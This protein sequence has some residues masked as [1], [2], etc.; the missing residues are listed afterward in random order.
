MSLDLTG[1]SD[2]S[3][4]RASLPSELADALIANIRSGELAIGSKLASEPKLAKAFNVSRNTVREAIGILREQRFVVTRHGI[5]TFVLGEGQVSVLPVEVGIEQL[6]STTELIS[7]AGRVPGS[8]DYTLSV[9]RAAGL[10]ED[11]Q[12]G[13]DEE[14][15]AIERVRTADG[16]PV[17]LCRDYIR[18][19]AIQSEV[20]EKY[21]GDESLFEFLERERGFAIQAARA[22]IVPIM[23]TRRIAELLQVPR[24]KPLLA[25]YQVH[26]AEGA[27]S[28]L[29][30]E[31]YFNLDYIDVHVR[32]TPVS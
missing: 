21:H 24:S 23:P 4:R 2:W 18:T 17:I 1:L 31:N 20:I 25:L 32:R 26:Y 7:R 8:R 5:G 10:S 28:F 11:F 27:N 6:T 12:L 16:L 19:N 13:P 9:Q 22:T 15:Y 30:S 3:S 14:V 29:Y